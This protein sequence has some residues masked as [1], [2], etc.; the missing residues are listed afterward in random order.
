MVLKNNFF[1][2]R[3]LVAWKTI[4]K[5]ASTTVPLLLVIVAAVSFLP[6]ASSTG[7]YG[8]EWHMVYSYV[9]HPE[10]G[11]ARYFYYDGHPTISWI[12][13]ISFNLLGINPFAWHLFAFLWKYFATLW[14]WYL[15]NAIWPEQKLETAFAAIVF[16][17]YPRFYMNA[18]A[19]AYFETWFAYVV[20]WASFYYSVKAVQTSQKSFYLIAFLLK[21][22]H[23]LTS[24]YTWGIELIR[25]F[26]IWAGLRHTHWNNRERLEQAIKASAFYLLPSIA[27]IVW[28]IW[29]YTSPLEHRAAPVLLYRLQSAP[30]QTFWNYFLNLFVD[31]FVMVTGSWNNLF[32]PFMLEEGPLFAVVMLTG[33]LVCVFAFYRFAQNGATAEQFTDDFKKMWLIIGLFGMISGLLPFH[34][35][36]YFVSMGEPPFNGRFTLG[37]LAGISLFFVAA[38]AL[39]ITSRQRRVVAFAIL[40]GLMVLWQNYAAGQ[41]RLLWQAQENFYR[42]LTWRVPSLRPNTALLMA[43]SSGA[44]FK[45]GRVF[46]LNILYEENQNS[47]LVLPYWIFDVKKGQGNRPDALV[48]WNTTISSLNYESDERLTD[49]KYDVSFNGAVQDALYLSYSD[50]HC[51]WIIEP[52]TAFYVFPEVLFPFSEPAARVENKNVS[53]ARLE[54]IFGAE[55]PYHRKWCYVFQRASL[56]R[57]FQD[58]NT[59]LALWKQASDARLQPSHGLEYL[60]FIDAHAYS[61]NWSEAFALTRKSF[62]KSDT[63][64]PFLCNH[65]QKLVKQTPFSDEKMSFYRRL[66]TL[67]GCP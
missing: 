19:V 27:L 52:E 39:F 62:N 26:F 3:S 50:H 9:S 46:V 45:R 51:L 65:W 42:Q 25:V 8:D 57:Q 32:Q 34:A 15:L 5:T 10:S 58:W 13:Q 35:A 55:Q 38:L 64:A 66:Q 56:A 43:S 67:L 17:L 53:G 30:F 37:S 2:I 12:Y 40:T 11:L 41:F 63:L 54:A 4:L 61:G 23:L 60:P 47:S 28:R 6:L 18:M 31:L 44:L 21:G 1:Q 22:V 16:M 33:S 49:W 29:F 24:E 48:G 7:F 59:I 14:F 20:L 36:G